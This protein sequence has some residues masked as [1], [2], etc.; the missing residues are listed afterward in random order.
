[1]FRPSRTYL[2]VPALAALL[3]A[4]IAGPTL[5]A[6]DPAGNNGTVKVSGKDVDGI[7]DNE[8]HQG[9]VFNVEFFGFDQG[10]NLMASASF[11][12]LLS[13]GAEGPTFTFPEVWIGEDPAS[14]AGT[15][16]VVDGID[17]SRNYNLNDKLYSFVDASNPNQGVH[18]RLTVHADGVN[19][20]DTVKSKTFWAQGCVR[21]PDQES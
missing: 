16:G 2:A 12:V 11:T 3:L 9:C 21:P 7:P 1:M 8:P 15:E 13:G 4:T 19:D 6:S 20:A 10:G 18:V 14:G 5:A 17:A